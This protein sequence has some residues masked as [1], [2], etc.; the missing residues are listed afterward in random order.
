[1]SC[2]A[3]RLASGGCCEVAEEAPPQARRARPRVAPAAR[4]AARLRGQGAFCKDGFLSLCSDSPDLISY[5]A[6]SPSADCWLNR[7]D[8]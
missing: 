5:I 4:V 6:V 7:S 1:M 3:Y 8:Q 2:P